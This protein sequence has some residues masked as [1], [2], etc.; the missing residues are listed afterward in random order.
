MDVWAF[1][2]RMGFKADI[3][4]FEDYETLKTLKNGDKGFLY[5]EQ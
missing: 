4:A 2:S 1:I 5:N 3:P